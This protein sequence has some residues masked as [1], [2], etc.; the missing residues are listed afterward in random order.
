MGDI[1]SHDNLLFRVKFR[2]YKLLSENTAPKDEPLIPRDEPLI[3]KDEPLIPK[4]EPLIPRDEPLIPKDEPPI[5]RD[6]P[7]TPKDEA[8]IPKDEAVVPLP[9]APKGKALDG[10]YAGRD[11]RTP[12]QFVK[13]GRCP[14]P[15]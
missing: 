6:E 8:F 3:P 15:G 10:P 13:G 14:A 12:R 5:P 7:F 2:F 1:I 4:D 11:G 9:P